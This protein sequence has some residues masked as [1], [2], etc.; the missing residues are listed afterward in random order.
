M[1]VVEKSVL[2]F[3]SARQMF[4]LVDRVED[5][6]EFLPWCGGT[7]VAHRDEHKVVA[8]VKIDY[9]GIRQSFTTEN[10][11]Q[12]PDLIKVR[13]VKGPFH[14][15][16]GEWRFIELDEAACKVQFHLTYVFAS[17]LLDLMIGPVFSYIAN[18]FVDAFVKRAEVVYGG[19][20]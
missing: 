14:E 7:E 2:V 8:T 18:T 5:Y 20:K 3:Y 12:P 15:L 1:A 4:D 16:E 19:G 10:T 6:P 9:H 13:L 17:K 11:R